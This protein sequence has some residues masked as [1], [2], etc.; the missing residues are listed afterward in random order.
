MNNDICPQAAQVM[1]QVEGETIVIVDQD[2]HV[3]KPVQ[4]LKAGA[5]EGQG[6]GGPSCWQRSKP[7]R[8]GAIAG[9]IISLQPQWHGLLSGRHRQNADNP[10][11]LP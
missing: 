6:S 3:L 5:G 9:N 4:G 7:G 8:I 11:Q 10:G 2:D 1:D